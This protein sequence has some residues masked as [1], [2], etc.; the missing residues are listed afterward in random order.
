MLF[1]SDTCR[2][3][4]LKFVAPHRPIIVTAGRFT[5][6]KLRSLFCKYGAVAHVKLESKYG[7]LKVRGGNDRARY[8][9]EQRP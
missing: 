2:W 9:N 4:A 3:G 5:D 7:A 1:G 6:K 8:D